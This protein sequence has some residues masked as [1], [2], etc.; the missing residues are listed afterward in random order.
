MYGLALV[1]ILAVMG[2]AIA[3][4]GDKLGTKVGKKKLTMFGLRPKHTSIIVT[5][6]TGILIAAATLGVLT[7]TSMDVRTALFGMEA[8]KAELTHLSQE[9]SQ[10]NTELEHS[11][12]VLQAQTVEYTALSAKV[13]ETVDRLTAT[14]TEL[15][16]VAAE[17][18]R[19]VAALSAIQHEYNKAR[20]QLD[21]A[22]QEIVGLQ[23]TRDELDQKVASLSEART[24]LQS[25]V[26]RLNELTANLKKGIAVVREGVV[27]FRAGEVLSTSVVR[28]GQSREETEQILGRIIYDTNRNIIERLGIQNDL[29][30]LW[31]ATDEFQQAAN[32]ITGTSESV[33]VR[34]TAAG[35]TIYGEPTIGRLDLFPNRLT[36]RSATVV[37]AETVDVDKISQD[38]EGA[39]LG[40]LQKVNAE[41]IKQGVLPDPIQGTVGAMSGAQLFE[42]INR[43]KRYSGKVEIAAVTTEDIHT[44]G[45]LKITIRVR[46]VP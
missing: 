22:Q 13:Q 42:T 23:A 29:E 7:L 40:F 12:S 16:R 38:M 20:G 3:Y 11:R 45:P 1:A 10:K 46:P 24:S 39:M 33:I 32:I 6:V 2:G 35:N 44:V 17:R 21:L 31:I 41:A 19:T 25:D 8:L 36:Y 15:S 37:Y 28:G 9:V 18:D 5:I 43:I 27:I 30:V 4:I 34:I 26:D 14:S